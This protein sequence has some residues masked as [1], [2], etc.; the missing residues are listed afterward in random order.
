MNQSDELRR[1]KAALVTL[2][3]VKFTEPEFQSAWETVCDAAARQAAESPGPVK[4]QGK[5]E[6]GAKEGGD[7]A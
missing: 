1:V 5:P 7:G 4:A 3:G 2:I 6:A